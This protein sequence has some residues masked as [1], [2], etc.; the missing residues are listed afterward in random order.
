MEKAPSTVT[1]KVKKT[2]HTET[3]NRQKTNKKC[4][5]TYVRKTWKYSS[6]T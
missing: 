2:T 1:T 4:A 6:K 3:P 5:K